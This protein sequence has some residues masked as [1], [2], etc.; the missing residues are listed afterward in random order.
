MHS[1]LF[2]QP[3]QKTDPYILIPYLT[4]CEMEKTFSVIF[5][6]TETKTTCRGDKDEEVRS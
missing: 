4:F 2:I 5:R 3:L 6:E 1:G